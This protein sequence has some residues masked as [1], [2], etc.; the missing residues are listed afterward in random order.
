MPLSTEFLK[1]LPYF[2]GLGDRELEGIARESVE[3]SYSDGEVI[4]LE[5]EP[6]SGM[7]AVISGRVRVF[8][9]SAAGREQVLFVARP[10]V[11]FN[12]VPVFDGGPNPASATAVGPCVVFL[13]PRG[14]IVAMLAACPAALAVTRNLA[15]RMRHL[16]LMIEGL[17]LRSVVGRLAKLL[18]D[19]TSA[20]TGQAPAPRLTQDEM[21]AMVGSVRDVIG[22]ALKQL[23]AAGAIKVQGHRILV[24]SREK[25]RSIS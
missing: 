25:L 9:S 11:S 19:T 13:I 6:S 23:E 2:A 12:D 17:S 14:S 7:Y 16:T 18:L 24:V 22:R 20:E 21:A 3:L 4:F 1:S 15:S 5:G 8:K 10:G